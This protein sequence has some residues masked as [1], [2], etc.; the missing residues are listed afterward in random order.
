M[1]SQRFGVRC[2][3]VMRPDGKLEDLGDFTDFYIPPDRSMGDTEAKH[4]R[5]MQDEVNP[6]ANH[7][8]YSSVL[9]Q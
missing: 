1:L 3:R 6:L 4:L 7:G 8:R 5:E 2:S 9:S